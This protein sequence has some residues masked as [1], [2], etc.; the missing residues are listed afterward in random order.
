M[1]KH[2]QFYSL[3]HGDKMSLS[4]LLESMKTQKYLVFHQRDKASKISPAHSHRMYSD[5]R[6]P[7]HCYDFLKLVDWRDALKI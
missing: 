3:T 7:N 2:K 6:A 4:L 5:S 1:L